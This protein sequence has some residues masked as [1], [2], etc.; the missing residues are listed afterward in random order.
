LDNTG[1]QTPDTARANLLSELFTRKVV[2]NRSY[3][4]T[5]KRFRI[6]GLTATPTR[7]AD[8]ERP[9]LAK[10][11]GQNTIH[12]VSLTSLIEKGYLSR[13]KPVRVKTNAHAE[14][15]V[16]QQDLEHLVRFN[17]LGEKWQDRIA[18]ISSRNDAIVAHY[19]KYRKRYGKTLIFAINV[20][21]ATLLA[22]EFQ[23]KDIKAE[24]VAAYRPDGSQ[25][26]NPEL[27]NSFRDGDLDVLTNV[28]I[29]TEG[30]DVPDIETVFLTRPTASEILIRQMIGRALRG[31]KAKGKKGAGTATAYIVSFED[32]WE[33]FR[34]WQ[35]P[36]DLVRDIEDAAE[37][38]ERPSRERQV[39][40]RIPWDLIQAA[41]RELRGIGTESPA[42][43]FEAIHHGWYVLE[44]ENDGEAGR[45]IVPVYE[46][47]VP[48]WERFFDELGQ[49]SRS[50]L[51][52]ASATDFQ[53]IFSSCDNPLPT[54]YNISE[55]F[56][57]FQL[58]G[59][60][61]DYHR[62]AERQEVE[63][64]AVAREIC[65][66]DLG[67]RAQA[68]L[69]ESKHTKLAKAVF[70]TLREYRAAVDDAIHGIQYPGEAT[71]LVRAVPVFDPG[72]DDQLPEGPAHD[73]ATLFEEVLNRAPVLLGVKTVDSDRRVDWT[74]HLIKGWYGHA[75]WE[76]A[77]P[78]GHGLIKLNRLV[79]SP[80]VTKE[81][82]LFLLWHEY[83]HLYLK[84]KHT[85]QF[86]GLEQKWP[87]YVDAN[88]ELH[89]LNERFGVQYW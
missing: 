62:F 67:A 33:R 35:S 74:K 17:E 2:D 16:T 1:Y 78:H 27:I 44:R 82:I 88:R 22:K 81:T 70:P 56:S 68:S 5:G 3:L 26:A 12:E 60:R 20:A 24:Y 29:M 32:H 58:G 19:L 21:H 38:A 39:L 87:G 89:S 75:K 46:H 65:D 52:K 18:R 72:P 47:Q 61:P 8:E 63:P 50:R 57:H 73:G 28:Q 45:I 69:I 76:A 30:V 80:A 36:L 55:A 64:A 51:A 31:K 43:I 25:A 53:V 37:P 42:D 86:R 59:E 49:V 23:R 4:T 14:E 66:R 9:L 77:T 54:E 13:P 11:F 15:G 85:G 7:T 84:Q 6:L 34:E 40:E 48:C 10:L 83:L 41:A 71:H 79:N